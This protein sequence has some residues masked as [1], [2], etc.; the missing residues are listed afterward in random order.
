MKFGLTV[1]G[2]TLKGPLRRFAI[3]DLALPNISSVARDFSVRGAL[4]G[5][6]GTWVS[7]SSKTRKFRGLRFKIRAPPI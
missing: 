5:A 6:S 2:F 7:S 3:W 1:L 4:G